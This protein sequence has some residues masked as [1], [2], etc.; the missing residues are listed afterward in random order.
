MGYKNIVQVISRSTGN[1]QYYLMCP[2]AVAE[3]IELEK[4]RL[5]KE[6][7]L[8]S[9]NLVELERKI[10]EL[11]KLEKELERYNQ[12]SEWLQSKFNVMVSRIEEQVFAS[13]YNVFNSYFKKW[14]ELLMGEEIM[15]VRLSLDFSP[16]IEQNGYD[17]DYINLSGGEK[18]AC[19]L[20]YR[21][22]LNQVIHDVV[23]TVKTSDIIILDEL[24]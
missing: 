8:I 15:K 2:R 17:L 22:A 3:S 4:A 9:I 19:A 7:E 10:L 1:K 12:L 18:T 23:G 20:A 13:I 5:E 14:F 16:L 24:Y 6:L 11:K 21:L